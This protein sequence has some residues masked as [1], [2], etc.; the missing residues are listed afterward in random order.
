MSALGKPWHNEKDLSYPLNRHIIDDTVSEWLST[1]MERL[2]WSNQD[3]SWFV[4]SHK[5][6]FQRVAT[7]IVKSLERVE[8]KQ[9]IDA[10]WEGW[11]FILP[12]RW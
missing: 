9:G 8:R 10:L 1:T 3:V 5:Y 7:V 6:S 4:G 11:K 12:L 2:D